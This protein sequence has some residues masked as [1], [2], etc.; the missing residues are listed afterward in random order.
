MAGSQSGLTSIVD[1]PCG[2]TLNPVKR[3]SSGIIVRLG[4]SVAAH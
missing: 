1:F 2:S 4:F 3:Y